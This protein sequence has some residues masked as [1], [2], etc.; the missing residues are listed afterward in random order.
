LR[1]PFAPFLTY[2]F[3]T[4]NYPVLPAHVLAQRATLEGST[5]ATAPVGTG[6]FRVVRW[7]RGNALVLAGNRAYYGGAPGLARIDLRFV[8]NPQTAVEQLRTGEAG[9]YLAAD[10]AVVGQLRTIPALHVVTLPIY[11]FTSLTFQTDAPALHD[12]ATRRALRESFALARDVAQVSRGEVQMADALRGLFT[13]A[14]VPL[15]PVRPAAHAGL[16]NRLTLIVDAGSALDRA[17]AIALA[18]DAARRGIAIDI[19][20]FATQTFFA[21]ADRGGPLN[22]GRFDLAL[23]DVLTGADPETSWLLAC[24]QIPPAG[25]N[26][27][28]FCDHAVDAALADA[29]R[30]FDA[31]RRRRDYQRV[32]AAIARDV[33]FVA[34]WQT[35]ET[36]ALPRDLEGFS[37]TPE[38]PFA[39]VER[40]HV[41]EASNTAK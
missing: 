31:E 7:D 22:A 9:A 38:T 10:P 30:T 26:V 5:L 25:F 3:E 37:G 16:P 17:L 6:P 23:H 12:P 11:G 34:L 14:Y 40:W 28:R 21:P 18:S 15:V 4:E 32:Q 24:D 29:L 8:A 33:P 13:W 39:H 41:A 19:L 2:F 20:P 1:A 27:S 35:R 36:E